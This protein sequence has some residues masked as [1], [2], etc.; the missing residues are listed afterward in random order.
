[1]AEQVLQHELSKQSLRLE[2]RAKRV[3]GHPVPHDTQLISGQ[4]WQVAQLCQVRWVLP[5]VQHH[6]GCG[7][8]TRMRDGALEAPLARVAEVGAARVRALE[9]P[10]VNLGHKCDNRPRCVPCEAQRPCSTHRLAQEADAP[11]RRTKLGESGVPPRTIVVLATHR[12]CLKP[13]LRRIEHMREHHPIVC[14]GAEGGPPLGTHHTMPA[15]GREDEHERALARRGCAHG[16][17]HDERSW[18]G[19]GVPN[20]SER[21]GGPLGA[22][23]TCGANEAPQTE[24]GRWEPEWTEHRPSQLLDCASVQSVNDALVVLGRWRHGHK[25][26]FGSSIERRRKSLCRTNRLH[27]ALPFF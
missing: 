27:T 12:V 9:V 4:R 24:L 14:D 22:T 6:L 10:Y 17:V 11:I 26:L 5:N 13:R 20:A 2:P 7:R 25:V 3:A 23:R 8:R 19:S 16:R 18:G 1:M 21:R 15:K